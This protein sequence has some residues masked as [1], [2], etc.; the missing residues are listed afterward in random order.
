[1]S[2]SS[3]NGNTPLQSGHQSTSAQAIWQLR[4]MGHNV[5]QISQQTGLSIERVHELLASHYRS[6]NPEGIEL[7]RYLALSRIESLLEVYLPQALMDSVT[8]QRLRSGEPVATQ[9]VEHPLKCAALVLACLKFAAELLHLRAVPEPAGG[10]RGL[11]LLDW[12][13]TQREFV[14]KAAE[15]APC[16]TPELPS[17]QLDSRSREDL[18]IDHSDSNP[19]IEFSE[20]DIRRQDSQAPPQ[21]G[22]LSLP[23][24]AAAVDDPDDARETPPPERQVVVPRN[25]QAQ[26]EA[27]RAERRRRFLS[28]EP[29]WL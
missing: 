9:D 15:E 29:D 16:D 12:L 8:T 17:G 18:A 13:A 22:A 23:E 7:H 5:H 28:G 6:I 20:I 4:V 10:Q 11:T 21:E 19:E 14:K 1:V 24:P 3:T 27:D 26:T 25:P 2:S